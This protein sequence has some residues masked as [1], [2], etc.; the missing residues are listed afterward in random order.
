MAAYT[1]LD[2]IQAVASS[3]DSD[4]VNSYD[5]SVES[6]QIANII[7]TVYN[8]VQARADLPEHFTLFELTASGDNTKPVLMTRP[9]TVTAIEWIQYNKVATGDTDPIF[10][11]INFLPINE[12]VQ[13]QDRLLVS[14]TNVA[15]FEQII[16][17]EADSITF[18]YRNDKAPTYYTTFDDYT[19]IF[20][21]FD[22][23]V[24]T[25]LQ[26][27]KTR[28]YGRKDQSFTM[29]NNFVPFLDRDLSTLLLNEAKV[30]AFSELKQVGHD[31]AKQWAQRGWTKMQKA[32]R[33]VN[34]DRNE[35]DRAPNYGRK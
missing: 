33:G 6:L 15:S 1:L 7:K 5:D 14:A 22:T 20:D 28:C 26:K 29:S 18:I 12:F 30:L 23:A 10:E 17:S 3:L 4:E 19:L 24:D 27:T 35:L 11:D 21:S 34:Q 31:V 9:S 16:G 25:T 32:K 8:D 2:Y 13:M